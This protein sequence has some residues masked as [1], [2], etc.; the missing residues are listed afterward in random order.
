MLALSCSKIRVV[1]TG[2][3]QNAAAVLVNFVWLPTGP[4][5]EDENL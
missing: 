1:E 3:A 2:P 5:L 4:S